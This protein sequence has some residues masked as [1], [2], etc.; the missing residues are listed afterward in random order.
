MKIAV[1]IDPKAK[2]VVERLRNPANAV[3][4][5]ARELD[6]QNLE[7]VSHIQQTRLNG[8]G[9]FPVEQHKLGQKTGRLNQALHAVPASIAGSRI[10]SS[11]GDNVSYAAV[12][13][14]GK[15]IMVPAR[16]GSVFLRTNARG[17]LVRNERGG[18]IFA[19]H[20]LKRKKEVQFEGQAYEIHMPER[21]PIWT[22]I[23]ERREATL[24]ALGKAFKES[25]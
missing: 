12:H 4:A 19:K 3:A 11:I 17:E 14:F 22:G 7:T 2:E 24:A 25:F 15:T 21:S 5:V 23:Q 8:V 6:R 20:S 10:T 13:E 18:A 9:P 16:R 1:Q